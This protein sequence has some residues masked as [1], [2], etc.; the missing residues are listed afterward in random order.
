MENKFYQLTEE[1]KARIETLTA[2]AE[3]NNQGYRLAAE[4]FSELQ[5]KILIEKD[6][7]FKEVAALMGINYS[8]MKQN[9]QAIKIEKGIAK[10]IDVNP[11]KK[12][13]V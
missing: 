1:Q 13:G 12:E 4:T 3:S 10:L 9:G 5:T 6:I 2:R 11:P 7:F 8:E